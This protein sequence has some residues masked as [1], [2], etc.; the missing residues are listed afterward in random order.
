MGK[1]EAPW[2]E[3][4]K[5]GDGVHFPFGV[6]SDKEQRRINMLV[7][8]NDR[9][10]KFV[11]ARAVPCLLALADDYDEKNMPSMAREVRAAAD[12]LSR[13][14][15]NGKPRVYKGAGSGNRPAGVRDSVGNVIRL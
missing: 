6:P 10:K 1:Q 2:R 5:A 8:M 3:Y 4:A 15:K 11:G 14:K 12:E 7:D 9:R 13:R